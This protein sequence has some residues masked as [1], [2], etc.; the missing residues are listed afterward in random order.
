VSIEFRDSV[1]LTTEEATEKFGW[2]RD[3]LY[4]FY[5]RGLIKP[6]KFLGDKKSYWDDAE[7]AKLKFKV[8]DSDQAQFLQAAP[9][10]E[11]ES[12]LAPLR[13]WLNTY[14]KLS[15]AAKQEIWEIATGK[16]NP[17]EELGIGREAAQDFTDKLLADWKRERPSINEELFALFGRLQRAGRIFDKDVERSLN[18]HGLKVGEFIVLGA[19]RRIGP[20]Y[21]LTPTELF[22]S[23]LITS[24]TITKRID[25]LEQR[26]L[27]ERH[28]DPAD[29]RGTMVC[30][31]PL[32]KE[33]ADNAISYPGSEP[34]RWLQKILTPL[35]RK[36]LE[37][38][39][40]KLLLAREKEAEN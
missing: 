23:L 10:E 6:K 22:K 3:S 40:R 24:G 15:E 13:L 20:P 16:Q 35:E 12:E 5:R 1:Y 38:V 11:E 29:R 18:Q 4:R 31:T 33:T 25:R 9:E 39:L 34:Y 8:F 32:G 17:I 7:L 27:V 2:S 19:L 30:L 36:V 37:R 14:P 28:P 26:G 21:C